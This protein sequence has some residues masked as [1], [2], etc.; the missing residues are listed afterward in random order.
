MSP[1][2]EADVVLRTKRQIT[3]PRSI[4]E[5]LGIEPGDVLELIVEES[6]LKAVP[7]K[8]L[9]LDTLREIQE[10]Y[11]RSG[12]SEDELMS[13]GRKARQEIAR[14]RGKKK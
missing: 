2:G 10:A 5:E 12:I 1:S 7:K 11:A 4:C 9:T 13:E 6:V 8:N 3:I 14:E